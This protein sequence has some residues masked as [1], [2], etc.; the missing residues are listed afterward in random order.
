M[1]AVLNVEESEHCPKI[2]LDKENNLFAIEGRSYPDDA[3]Q[4]YK[5]VH[6][7]FKEYFQEPNS[8]TELLMRLEYYNS[9]TAKELLELF[10]N[11][12]EISSS[13]KDIKIVWFYNDD[14]A[15][16]EERGEELQSM[17]DMNFELRSC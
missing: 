11:L 5:Q 17:V 7:W 1:L 14:D 16:M 6:D 8:S 13:G 12:D 15:I 10:S 3:P 9:S 4:F 2:T